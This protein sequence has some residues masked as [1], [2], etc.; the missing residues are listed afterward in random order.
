[1]YSIENYFD[2]GFATP[3]SLSENFKNT[4][5]LGEYFSFQDKCN[6]FLGHSVTVKPNILSSFFDSIVFDDEIITRVN[7][8]IGPDVYVWSSAIF[9]KAPGDKKIVSFHQDNPYWQL[10]SK[11]VVTAWVSFTESNKISGGMQIVPQSHKFGLISDLDISNPRE[12][13]LEGKKTTSKNDLL[14]YKHELED[15]VKENPP[16]SIDLSAGTF[17]LHHLD[18]VH[19]SGTNQS[20]H[21]RIGY[22]IRYVSSKTKHIMENSDSGLHISGKKDRY[23]LDEL[24]PMQDFSEGALDCYRKSMR[25]AGSF[26]NKS[27]S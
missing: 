14:S 26:G 24:R 19:G 4:D 2:N 11:E 6:K 13:Y 23:F 9:A 21:Y 12:A 10:S 18:A 7:N 22:A 1:M 27:Y 15:F 25:T 16:V 17:S 20:S 5:W 3:F 8:L